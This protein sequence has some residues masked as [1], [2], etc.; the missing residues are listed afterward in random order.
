[1]GVVRADFA[2]RATL[3]EVVWV[4]AFARMTVWGW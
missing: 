2:T 1:M 3:F 4:L